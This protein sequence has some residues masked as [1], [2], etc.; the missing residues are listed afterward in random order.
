VS[1]TI[2]RAGHDVFRVLGQE[3]RTPPLSATS[4]RSIRHVIG[5]VRSLDWFRSERL[6]AVVAE[7]SVLSSCLATEATVEQAARLL[8][9]GGRL[10][11]SVDSLLYGLARLAE[12]HRWPELA[13]TNAGD[14]VL[15]PSGDSADGDAERPA[16]LTRCFGPEELRDLVEAA[17][18][19]VDWV[20]PRTVLPPDV[21]DH[22]VQNDPAVLPE[23]VTS[24]LTL[25]AERE[26][27]SLGNYLALS[28]TRQG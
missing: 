14:V 9:P 6:D 7:G 5:D 8:K 22:A 2:G 11:L 15:V 27:E 28:A 17:G 12:Q 4:P 1:A 13:D 23:L 25:A 19:T 18:F 3:S 16:A 20:R 10:L 24:E 26:G 21:V